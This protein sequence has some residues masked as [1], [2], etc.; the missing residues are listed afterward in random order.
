M[1]RNLL[2]YAILFIIISCSSDSE[3]K[4]LSSANSITSFIVKSEALNYQA[5]IG[6]NAITGSLPR[7]FVLDAVSLQVEIS[8]GATISPNPSTITSLVEPLAFTITAEDGTTKNYNVNISRSLASESSIVSVTV[9]SDKNSVMADEIASGTFFKRLPT[10]FSLNNLTLDVLISPYATINPDPQDVVDYTQPV[11]FTVTAEDGS[12][13]TYQIGFVNMD[14]DFEIRCTDSNA[15]KWFGGDDR[16]NPDY[17][18]TPFDRNVGTGQK[19]TF[20]EDLD[21]DTFGVLFASGFTYAQA[22]FYYDQDLEIR[23]DIRDNQGSKLGTTSVIVPPTYRGGW[24]YFDL[25]DI[26]F[27]MKADET[28][29]F[30]WYL[31]NGGV[32]GVNT[33]SM[34]TNQDGIQNCDGIGMSGQSKESFETS[35]DSWDLWYEHGWHFN[36][37]LSGKR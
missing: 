5:T 37:S 16:D 14:T 7:D 2:F 25:S 23:L 4:I 34:A 26:P 27:Y 13:S 32:I 18:F 36:Y 6:S 12:E 31:V 17:D 20:T 8:K 15:S 3:E 28:Y 33:G 10:F 30:T 21:P 11:D 9:V 19:L 22:G 24:V 35:L 1:K 29:I